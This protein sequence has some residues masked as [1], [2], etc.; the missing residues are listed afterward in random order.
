[1]SEFLFGGEFEYDEKEELKFF[2][3]NLKPSVSRSIIEM[4]LNHASNQGV[5][6]ILESHCIYKCLENL[7]DNENKNNNLRGDDTNGDSN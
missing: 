2:L 3:N 7:K 1:M 4:A 6:S 5:F